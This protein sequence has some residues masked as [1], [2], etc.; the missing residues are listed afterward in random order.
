[1]TG[2]LTGYLNQ[3]DQDVREQVESLMKQM[4]EKQV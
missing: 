1:M 4:A 3:V 2:K